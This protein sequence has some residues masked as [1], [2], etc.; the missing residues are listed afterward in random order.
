MD[1]VNELEKKVVRLEKEVAKLVAIETKKQRETK[2]NE[3][4]ERLRDELMS[5][6]AHDM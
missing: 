4:F 6:I 2:D 1:K 5:Q 3:R